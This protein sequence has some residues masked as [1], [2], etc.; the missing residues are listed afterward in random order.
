MI[1]IAFFEPDCDVLYSW[2]GVTCQNLA[3]CTNQHF[4]TQTGMYNG[5]C[6]LYMLCISSTLSSNLVQHHFRFNLPWKTLH[7]CVHNFCNNFQLTF[8]HDMHCKAYNLYLFLNL[9]SSCAHSFCNHFQSTLKHDMHCTAYNLYLLNLCS[10]IQPLLEKACFLWS[11][12][13][14]YHKTFV[15]CFMCT[16]GG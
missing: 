13:R 7:S 14:R 9:W 8:K 4:L 12:Q 15:A 3:L 1:N 16:L 5:R 11:K 10:N 2:L 6:I